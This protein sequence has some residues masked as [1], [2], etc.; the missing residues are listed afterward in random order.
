[1]VATMCDPRIKGRIAKRDKKLDHWREVLTQMVSQQRSSAHTV[2]HS[3]EEGSDSETTCS[4]S[5]DRSLHPQVSSVGVEDPHSMTQVAVIGRWFGPSGSQGCVREDTAAAQVKEYLT[6]A[7]AAQHT[8]PLRYWASK[9]AVWP[10]LSAVAQHLLSCPPTSVPSERVFSHAGNI[11]TP[12]RSC[13]RPSKVNELVF[14]KVNNLIFDYPDL[15]PP[16]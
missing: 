15:T 9:E 5:T 1:M 6:E 7:Y 16:D 10:D 14:L 4:G 8:C 12:H 3:E 11:V 13:T 2:E